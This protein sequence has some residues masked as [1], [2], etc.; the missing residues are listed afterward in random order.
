MTADLRAYD[1]S[2]PASGQPTPG[3]F[4]LVGFYIGGNTPHVWSDE[5]IALAPAR[6]GL[7]I[8]VRSAG[9]DPVADGR[10]AALWA[11]THHLPSGSLIALDLETR[12]DSAYLSAFDSTLNNSWYKCVAYGSQSSVTQMAEPSGGFWVANWNGIPS[13]NGYTA[14][15]YNSDTQIGHPWDLSS[16]DPAASW[17]DM[18]PVTP[19]PNQ[20]EDLDMLILYVNGDP[21][22]YGLSGGRVWLITSPADLQAYI[23]AGIKSV[24][25]SQNEITSLREGSA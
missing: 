5:E 7:P 8:F 23:D 1:Q 3:Q 20:S 16:A 6:Y 10:T 19:P 13:R 4:D 9:G 2:N 22:V 18:H 11:L 25:V 17:W 14:K 15:Q 12:I 21:A 24:H